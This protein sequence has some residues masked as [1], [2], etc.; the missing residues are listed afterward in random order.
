[1]IGMRKVRD[2]GKKRGIVATSYKRVNG[3]VKVVPQSF[4]MSE[5]IRLSNSIFLSTV[6]PI[7][8]IWKYIGERC[9]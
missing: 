2:P 3:V 8:F 7:F 4:L 9:R 6:L 5:P 1:M